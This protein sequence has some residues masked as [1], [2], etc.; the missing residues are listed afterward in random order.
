MGYRCKLWLIY[1]P[2]R[3]GRATVLS[4]S[5]AP[6]GTIRHTLHGV[7]DLYCLFF[8]QIE[9]FHSFRFSFFYNNDIQYHTLAIMRLSYDQRRYR[10]YSFAF[11]FAFCAGVSFRLNR[12]AINRAINHVSRDVPRRASFPSSRCVFSLLLPREKERDP[13]FFFTGRGSLL[14]GSYDKGWSM[15]YFRRHGITQL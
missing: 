5:K 8:N 13:D 1:R 12:G 15:S 7:S 9:I 3:R 2:R 10:Y 11:A 14:G 4:N 6:R